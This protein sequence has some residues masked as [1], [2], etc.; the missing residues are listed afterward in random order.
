MSAVL[1]ELIK[2]N[3]DSQKIDEYNKLL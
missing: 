2:D 3:E 1:G